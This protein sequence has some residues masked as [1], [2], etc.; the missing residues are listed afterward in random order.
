MAT[1]AQSPRYSK[2]KRAILRAVNDLWMYEAYS[3]SQA[4]SIVVHEKRLTCAEVDWL[5][6]H[7]EEDLLQ[8]T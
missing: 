5:T 8:D 3:T 1:L 2:H 6:E 4:I 7:F